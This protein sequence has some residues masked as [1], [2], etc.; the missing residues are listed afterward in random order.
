MIRRGLKHQA[1]GLITVGISKARAPIKSDRALYGLL[2]C[3]SKGKHIYHENQPH[4][5]RL[6]VKNALQDKSLINT[7]LLQSALKGAKEGAWRV[8]I[9]DYPVC[10]YVCVL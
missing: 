4:L 9:D 5:S 10:A 6:L 1:L 2:G 7:Q 3:Y 8:R